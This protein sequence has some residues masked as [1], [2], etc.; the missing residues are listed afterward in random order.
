M[1]LQLKNSLLEFMKEKAYNPLSAQELADIFDIHPSE[2]A[3]F[4][5]MLDEMEQDGYIYKTK[6]NKYGLPSKMNLFVGRLL[7]H[8]RG[9]GF[10]ISTEEGIED[11]FIP[12]NCMNGALHNDKVIARIIQIPEEGK[13]AEGEIIRII[14]RATKT[15]VGTFEKSKNFGFVV[16]DNKRFGMDIYIPKDLSMNAQDGYKVVCEITQWPK[17]GRNPEGKIIEILGKKDEKGVDIL[18]IIRQHDLP[19]EFPIK[20]LAEVD[21]IDENIPNEEIKR[22]LDLRDKV[23]FTIDGADA[24]DLDDAV[25][26]DILENGN[27][28]LG[29]HIADVTHYVKEN[30]KLD[31]EALKRGTSVYLVDRVIPMLPKKLSNGVCSLNPNVDRLTLSIFMEIDKS[32]NVVDYDIAETVINSKARMVYTDVSDILEKEDKELIEKYKELVPH[33]KNMEKLAKILMERR[34]KR[35]AVDF[36]FP[37]AKIILDK[38]GNVEDVVKYERRIANKIIEEFMLISN[39]T[40][41]EHFYWLSIPFVY[42]VH[43][44][45]HIEKMENFNKFISAFGYFIKGDLENIQPKSL[46]ILLEEVKGKKEERAISTIMLR[47]LKQ[48]RYSPEC[49]GHFGLAA[50]YYSHFTSPI[51]RYPDLQI[52]RI[53]KEFL[54]KKLSDSRIQS[55]KGIVAYSSEQSSL[56]ERAA[57][58]AERDVEDLKKAEYMAGKIGEEFEGVVSSVTSFGIFIELD[59]TIEGLIRLSSLDDDYYIFDADNYVLRGENT[60][61]T[62]TIGDIVKVKVSKVNVE[63]K[64]IEFS[65]VQD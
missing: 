55:L 48:A 2:R 64:E 57:E 13:R 49:I 46:Q 52:H 27:Y 62:Y 41:A 39:E 8:Q 60:K 10:V 59:N 25:S 19:E 28:K 18:S 45:P 32:G 26:I 51:R 43:E 15:V 16:P 35:G 29:V 11:L 22:R 44:T 65:I 31:K 34:Y 42:R 24:K 56:R 58:D 12:A 53:I 47:S 30:S 63:F 54:N 7:T 14:E 4:F 50:K 38:N 9:Y 5:N 17:K 6:K 21:R 20:V 36:D 1:D 37:E 33:F 40:I 3:M 61:K 23:I